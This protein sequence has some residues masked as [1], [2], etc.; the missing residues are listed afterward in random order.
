MSRLLR[1]RAEKRRAR[2]T[3]LE[4]ADAGLG[5]PPA[6]D[7]QRGL[8]VAVG[9]PNRYALGMSN[10][11]F[12]AVHRF[13]HLLPD[14]T[15]ERFFLPDRAEMDEYRRTGLPLRTLESGSPVRG[16]DVVA[17]SITFEPD[18]IHLV[19]MLQLAGIPPLAAD[20]SARDPLVI[21]GGPV[22]FLNPEPL[23]PFIDA[24]GVGEA[25]A[26]LPTLSGILQ[27]ETRDQRLRGFAEESGFYVPATHEV[28]YAPEG[29]VL[30]R[31]VQG[32]PRVVAGPHGQGCAVPAS[33]HLHPHPGHRDVG[34][35]PGRGIARLPPRS[36]GSAGP[37]TTIC[38][39]VPSTWS[40]CWRWP[41]WLALTPTG[42]A[43]F[44]PRWARTAKSSRWFR[45]SGIRHSGSAFPPIRFEDVRDE[46]VRPLA[47]SGERTVA[48]APEV[49][50]DRLR[51]AIHK[52]VTNDEILDKTKTLLDAGIENLKALPDGGAAG[53][54]RHRRGSDRPAGAPHPRPRAGRNGAAA[55]PSRAST[56]SSRSR[57]LPSSGAPWRR[58]RC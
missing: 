53:G 43:W 58:C 47:E 38:R 51:K 33:S 7:T 46:F 15:S 27:A 40:V 48:I 35:V 12:Q 9:Y 5:V 54:N 55:A 14:T 49:G 39:S 10:V 19:E 25:E 52:R 13:F 11:G 30:S 56:P 6:S 34:Q 16:F 18:L 32:A 36:A 42:S 1:E 44:P 57:A 23:A 24:F 22:T 21:A 8:R 3:W 29:Q 17:F 4:D 31:R 20:R 26:L 41:A 45:I 2:E 28:E 37:A 50:T